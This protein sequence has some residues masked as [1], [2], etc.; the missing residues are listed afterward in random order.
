M[1]KRYL[2]F[3]IDGTLVAGGYGNSYIPESTK[4]ALKK[5]EEAGHFLC[6]ST[7]RSQAMAYDLMQEMHFHNM[8]SDG[9]YGITLDDELFGITPLNRDDVI[10]LI[11][12][13]KE[14]NYIWA[15]QPENSCVRFAP[16]ERFYEF[17]HDV[18]MET[19]VIEGLDPRNYDI[20][21]KAYVACF[22]PE[23]LKL[24]SLKKLPW[25]RFHKEYLFVEPGD[26]AFGIKQIM[27]HFHADYKDAVVFGDAMND[28]TM[29]IKDWTCVAMGNAVDA[30]KEKADFITKDVAD[31]GIYYACEQLGL[32]ED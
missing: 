11:D 3:D 2:F 9:G 1:K 18:Y 30:L 28:M 27:D 15:I 7:G 31:D 17:T 16:D 5:L 26:K 8:V 23:E 25:C 4:L 22:Y 6:I 13:C 32:F 20:L 10:A 21:Y 19:K 12:E 24:E 14:K 29:F